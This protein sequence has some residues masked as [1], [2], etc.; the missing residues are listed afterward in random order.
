MSMT[1][2]YASVLRRHAGEWDKQAM[3][4]QAECARQAA[5]HM[6][7]LADRPAAPLAAGP[8]TEGNEVERRVR[9]QAEQVCVLRSEKISTRRLCA[10][11]LEQR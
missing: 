7:V 11:Q 4:V 10:A 3:P 6:D 1:Q 2:R 5:R 8:V 9:T